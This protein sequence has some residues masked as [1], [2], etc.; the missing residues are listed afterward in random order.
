MQ[1]WINQNGVQSGPH[2]RED[3][4]KMF[5]SADA[6]VWRSGLDDWVKVSSLAELDGV[7]GGEVPA[8]EQPQEDAGHV[9]VDGDAN[10]P[11]PSPEA[12]S[13]VT[14]VGDAVGNPVGDAV[15]S[16]M[17][18]AVEESSE[19]VQPSQQ[20]TPVTPPELPDNL[21]QMQQQQYYAP[22]YVAQ[23]N[24]EQCPPTNLVWAIVTAFLCCTP[25]SVVAI[26]YAIKVRNKFAAGDIEGAKRASETGAW[27][28]IA[29]IILAII[30]S[31]FMSLVQMMA[32]MQ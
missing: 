12:Q 9:A 26:F 6:Y 14:A 24:G 29:S 25:L 16:P 11:E 32:T 8:A 5:V 23:P 20:H 7:I 1:Y 30:L 31:P 19:P 27:W 13:V 17:G 28:I 3:L 21:A 10:E 22:Q 2:T 15:G 18:E 4:E